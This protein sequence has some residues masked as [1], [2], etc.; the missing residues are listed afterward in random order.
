[1]KDIPN[2]GHQWKNP[3]HPGDPGPNGVPTSKFVAAHG[4]AK[5]QH[6]VAGG[7][8]RRVLWLSAINMG[9]SKI[10]KDIQRC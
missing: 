6:P 10:F 2:I 7:R 8:W 9:I 5:Q 1:M 3:F 4:A